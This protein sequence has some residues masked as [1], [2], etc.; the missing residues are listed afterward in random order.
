MNIF[1][2]LF[3]SR[4]KPKVNGSINPVTFG[5]LIGSSSSSGKRVNQN[6]AMN[7]TAV[8][9][10]VRILS[11]AIAGL[12]LHTY[13]HTKSGGKEKV[14]DTVLESECT[15]GMEA[16]AEKVPPMAPALMFIQKADMTL[17]VEI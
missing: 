9:A 14:T 13:K 10:C 1:K 11:E 15:S 16:L 3:H 5:R 4:D 17:G 2:H 8:Y 12:P 7:I 6:S